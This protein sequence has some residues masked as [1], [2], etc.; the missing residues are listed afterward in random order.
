MVLSDQIAEAKVLDVIWT[1]SKDGFLKPRVQ[2]EPVTL[3]GAR[4]E[5]ATGFNA[6]FIEDNKIADEGNYEYMPRTKQRTVS[7]E[8]FQN[9][10]HGPGPDE[11]K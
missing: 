3:G 8:D 9:E 6:K 7:I 11:E 4:I 2:I 10:L 1:A 5:Y